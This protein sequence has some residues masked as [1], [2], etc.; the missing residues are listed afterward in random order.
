MTSELFVKYPSI[1]LRVYTNELPGKN[2]KKILI[3]EDDDDDFNM[4]YTAILSLYGA[5]DILR[6]E[7]GI[8][9]SSLLETSLKP[10]VIFLD[11]NLPYKNGLMCLKEIKNNPELSS[12]QVIMYSTSNNVK[13]VDNSYELGA[14]FYLVKQTSYRNIVRQLSELF[15]QDFSAG[16]SR[17][18]K[19]DFLLNASAVLNN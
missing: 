6:T 17:P 5:V 15:Q 12:I 2:I 4:F 18:T 13:H 11:I 3:A 10:D 14:D 19:A 9:L 16:K 7:N 1:P 8:M